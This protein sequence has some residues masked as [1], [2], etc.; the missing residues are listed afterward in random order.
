MIKLVEKAIPVVAAAGIFLNIFAVARADVLRAPGGG[1]VRVVVIGVNH[2]PNLG[3]G[4]QLR[5]A[6]PDAL[7]IAAAL[8]KDGVH[9][10]PILDGQVT[11]QRIVDAMN[12]L[13]KNSKKGDLAIISYAGH[14]M[15]TPEYPRWKGLSRSGA[16]EQIA[17]SNFSFAGPGAGEIIVNIEMRAWLSRLDAKGVDTVLVMD[18][19]FGGGMRGV[20]PRSGELRV[21]EVKGAGDAAER[22]KFTGI[23]M[24]DKEAR[25]DVALM[26]HVTFLSGATSNSVVPEMSTLPKDPRPRGALSY[27]VARA[28]EGGGVVTR[29][30]LF[31]NVLQNV[32]QASNGRQAVDI[33]PRS[34]DPEVLGKQIFVF[35]EPAAPTSG[36]TSVPTS[37]ATSAPT[38]VPTS[39]ATSTPTSVPTSVATSVPTPAA[40]TPPTP[41]P[42]PSEIA[43]AVHLAIVNGGADAWSTIEK[44]RAPLV[45]A[46]DRSDADLVWDVVKHEA[47]A[48]GD[49]VM[50][51]VDGSMIGDVA[52]RTWAIRRLRAISQSRVLL[53]GLASGGSLLTP[54][55]QASAT[56][57]DLRGEHLTAF[58]IAADGTVQMLYPS[59]TG[60]QRVCPDP[61][62]DRWSCN[63]EVEPPFGADTIVALATSKFPTDFVGWLKAHHAKRDA[64]L[65]P[66]ELGRVLDDDSSARL[67]FAG[68]FT[69]STKEIEKER[70]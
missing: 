40:T 29:K 16:S 69:N 37:V 58:N 61:Q 65:I 63:L 13:I 66:A 67:G 32:R 6:T 9:T 23:P 36:A 26:P 12:D 35:G 7:D 3:D 8:E 20:D 1:T 28:L 68:V 52:D 41:A 18:S 27:Y 51:R 5:G 24:T 44:G 43:D 49:L 22:E 21:R 38:L 56:A 39:V 11:R 46:P 60:E 17:L 62:G 10:V 47:L 19:C 33:V 48:R 54:G 2:Y 4:A 42:N 34:A 14:G 45:A 15:Q 31:Q 59:A 57:E 64:A 50:Q 25:A 70:P 30:S 53:V 55:D